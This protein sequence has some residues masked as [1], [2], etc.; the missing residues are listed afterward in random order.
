MAPTE[1]DL[2][3]IHPETS[4]TQGR[5]LS[6]LLPQAS[7]VSFPSLPETEAQNQFLGELM[8]MQISRPCPCPTA[9]KS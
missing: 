8:T 2:S 7:L 9:L 4:H 1:V 6:P 5:D 3:Q